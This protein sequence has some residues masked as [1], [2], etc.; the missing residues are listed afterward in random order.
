MDGVHELPQLQPVELKTVAEKPPSGNHQDWMAA[1][2]ISPNDYGYVD[3]IIVREGH[4][5]P[6]VVN[7]GLVDCS[8]AVNGG[9]KA[10]GVCQALPGKKMASAG[11]DWATNPITQL[12]WCNKY[13]LERYGSWANA[14]AFWKSHKWW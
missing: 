10:Y 12:K 1:A 11:S 2:G 9:E 13:A 4:Y 3:Y 6:C 5:D 8:Y 14:V 7:G